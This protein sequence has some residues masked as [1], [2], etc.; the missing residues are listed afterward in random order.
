MAALQQFRRQHLYQPGSP[1]DF[2]YVPM[3]FTPFRLPVE[4]VDCFLSGRW[5]LAIWPIRGGLRWGHARGLLPPPGPFLPRPCHGRTDLE[6]VDFFSPELLECP[7][8]CTGSCRMKRL[9]SAARYPRI[10]GDPAR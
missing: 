3:G 1:R 2:A 6:T 4:G 7:S 8:T 5:W 9:C 10:H